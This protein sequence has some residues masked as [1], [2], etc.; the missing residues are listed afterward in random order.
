MAKFYAVK[1]GKKP[2]IYNSWPE[3]QAQVKGFS[4]AIYKSFTTLSEA[5]AFMGDSES[6][7]SSKN[8]N[9]QEI[10]WMPGHSEQTDDKAESMTVYVD[11]SFDKNTGYFGYGGV[12]LYQ[13]K[14]KSFKG[15]R[16]TKE[17][18]KM[19][20]VAG[21]II[22]AMQAIKIALNAEASQVIIYHDYMGIA[23]W[24]LGTWQAKNKYTQEYQQFMK[25]KSKMVD[26]AFVK[27]PA[28]TGD[29]YNEQADELAKNGI[30]DALNNR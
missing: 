26:I 30:K 15:G 5:K 4:G 7:T 25:A 27:V 9:G 24:A 10:R 29:K 18:A 14:R 17:L 6:Q 20:N 19:R 21:E 3:C 22:A 8:A 2:G 23:E 1:K 28:H 12:V 13:G 16:N 11:G